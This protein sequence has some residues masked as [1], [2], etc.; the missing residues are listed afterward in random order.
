MCVFHRHFKLLTSRWIFGCPL[1][2]L[3][4]CLAPCL[5]YLSKHL[6]HCE[7]ED[8]NLLSPSFS[9]SLSPTARLVSPIS[10]IGLGSLSLFPQPWLWSKPPWSPPWARTIASLVDFSYLSL[11]SSSLFPLNTQIRS[12]YSLLK[13]PHGCTMH[14][15]ILETPNYGLQSPE[16]SDIYSYL[17]TDLNLLFL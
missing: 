6:L 13:S 12:W 14:L 3:P 4:I 9:P 16:W 11:S 7:K 17:Q 1:S 8:T 10:N 2:P 15:K 5:H